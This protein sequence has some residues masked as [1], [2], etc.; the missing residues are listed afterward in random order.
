MGE[1]FTKPRKCKTCKK[2][3]TGRDKD[4]VR[5]RYC[6]RKCHFRDINHGEHQVKAG[7]QGALYAISKRGSGKVG[8]IKELGKH[9]HRRVVEKI[10]GRKLRSDEI[11]HHKDHN[12]HNNDPSNLQIVTRSE[13]ARIHFS[14]TI[15]SSEENH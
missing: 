4:G 14:K 6:S 10:I 7:K 3:F 5:A 1:R 12:K 8:Y 11:I 15:S 9:Q 13:H 2:S